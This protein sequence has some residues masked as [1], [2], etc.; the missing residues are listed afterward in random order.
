MHVVVHTAQAI[1]QAVSERLRCLPLVTVDAGMPMEEPM[2]RFGVAV[3]MTDVGT[4]RHRHQGNDRSNGGGG[5]S[6]TDRRG[7]SY[8]KSIAR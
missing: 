6:S 3:Q 8:F 1:L 5:R 4:R 7:P 2:R